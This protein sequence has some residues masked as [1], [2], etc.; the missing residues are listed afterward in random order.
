MTDTETDS[1]AAGQDAGAEVVEPVVEALEWLAAGLDRSDPV[2][3]AQAAKDMARVDE[4]VRMVRSAAAARLAAVAAQAGRAGALLGDGSRVRVVEGVSR[5]SVRHSSLLR[6]LDL[7]ADTAEHRVDAATGEDIGA[8]AARLRLR[9]RC[10]SPSWR[11]GELIDLGID[12]A[13]HCTEQ[14]RRTV[15]VTSDGDGTKTTLPLP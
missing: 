12:P 15:T 1:A 9:D 14:I 13:E 3:V 4:A 8:A 10:M 7:L 5:R 2:G 11:W 6:T